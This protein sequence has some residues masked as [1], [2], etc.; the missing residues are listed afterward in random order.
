MLVGANKLQKLKLLVHKKGSLF[1]SE[2]SVSDIFV[3][4]NICSCFRMK[5]LLLASVV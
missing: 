1:V 3:S 2:D 4:T 5:L